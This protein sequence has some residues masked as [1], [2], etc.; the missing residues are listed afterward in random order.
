MIPLLFRARKTFPIHIP[1]LSAYRG[2]SPFVLLMFVF[3]FRSP[4]LAIFSIDFFSSA[5]LD[6]SIKQVFFLG[7]PL[8][9][10]KY[11]FG[12]GAAEWFKIAIF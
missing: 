6:V 4:L 8:R 1:L 5:L 7:F 9:Y 2:L 12:L 3:R 10:A 11:K